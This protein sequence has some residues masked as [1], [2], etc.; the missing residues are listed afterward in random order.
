MQ[1]ING[2]INNITDNTVLTL[3]MFD[4]VHIAHK[5]I[6][7]QCVEQAKKLNAKSVLTRPCKSG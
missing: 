6:L 4:G 5:K 3:G 2:F 1:I 7:L